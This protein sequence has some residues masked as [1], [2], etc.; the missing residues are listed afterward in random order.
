M[1]KLISVLLAV[2]LLAGLFT[3]STF[4]KQATGYLYFDG[5]SSSSGGSYSVTSIRKSNSVWLS[6]TAIDPNTKF[7]EICWK[8]SEGK[9]VTDAIDA[10]GKLKDDVNVSSSVEFY[11]NS[12]SLPLQKNKDVILNVGKTKAGQIT[13]NLEIPV[14]YTG[15]GNSL[16]FTII[17]EKETSTDGE[18]ST[19][20]SCELTFDYNVSLCKEYVESSSSDDDDEPT[21][22]ITPYII[23]SNY[24][25]G[26]SSV[27][28][29]TEF[30]LQLTLRNTSTEYDLENIVM[31]LTPQGVFSVASSSNTI[32]LESLGKGETVT[33]TILIRA[34]MTKLTDDND[35]NGI[36]LR[37][38]FQYV[39]DST[40]YNGDSSESITIPVDYP[41]RFELGFLEQDDQAFIGEDFYLYLPMVNKGRSGVY[42]LT[43][44]VQG[45][46]ISNAG[47]SQYIGNLA[48]GTETGADFSV[49]F[50]EAGEQTGTIVITYEDA[51]MEERTV[52]KEFT[53]NVMS[54]DDM[55]AEDDYGD[56]PTDAEMPGDMS[57]ESGSQMTPGNIAIAIGVLVAVVVIILII[58]KRKAERAVGDEEI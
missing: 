14:R 45:E 16:S 30:P 32:Y 22:P 35:S 7:S 10:N 17:Y 37:F 23:V 2:C 34:G 55:Y 58:R 47:Q 5:A 57:E 18:N 12:S 15:S 27:T 40:R 13:F 51:N 28:A 1:K 21:T 11:Y 39:A 4:A 52:T 56:M 26:G 53:V 54:Y 41:D 25:Y 43:A 3:I 8:N 50:T 42:N 36:N 29:G 9:T 6:F 19:P 31:N 33:K 44:S 38:N 46:S 49:R 24:S 20:E 48:A